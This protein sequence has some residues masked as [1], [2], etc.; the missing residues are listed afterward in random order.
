[1]FDKLRRARTDL[2]T[3]NALL[4]AA[5]RFAHEEGIDQPGEEHLLLAAL[6]LDDGIARRALGAFDIDR[7]SLQ[8]GIAGQH[9]E[10]LQSIGVH[11]DDNAIAAALPPAGRPSGAYRAQASA[12]RA[13]QHA[14][15][16]AKR[17]K[18]P[19]NSGHVLLASTEAEHGPLAR[20]FDHLGVDRTLLREHTRRLL[21]A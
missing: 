15:E 3:M 14:V 1:M 5:E 16:L 9:D 12:Q 8:A 4:P 19:L 11:A 2:A 20:S 10:T 7:A 17:D 18:V 13:F 6:D 21:A